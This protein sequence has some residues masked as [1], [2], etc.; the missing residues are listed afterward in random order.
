MPYDLFYHTVRQRY[1]EENIPRLID[2]MGRLI[3]RSA[4]SRALSSRHATIASRIVEGRPGR[5]SAEIREALEA[6]LLG[7]SRYRIPIIVHHSNTV[8]SR[9][10]KSI[11]NNQ[12][13]V[14]IFG[15][16]T[17]IDIYRKF[18]KAFEE[19]AFFWQQFGLTY[20]HAGQH[21]L[22]LETLSHAVSIHNHPY[23]RHA[24][25]VAKLVTC[26]E[27]GPQGLGEVNFIRFRSEG[28]I[29]LEEVHVEMQT[30]E[31]YG[32]SALVHHNLKISNKYDT[33]EDR[34]SIKRQ[35]HTMLAL[36]LRVHPNMLHAQAVYDRLHQELTS[37]I[38]AISKD[39]REDSFEPDI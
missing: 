29:E 6:L 14:F 12:F 25:A 15:E 10:F 28:T 37:D 36:Y 13:L 22:A 1:P 32:I 16:Q 5:G 31:D 3:Q 20:L 4:G 35:Y 38:P 2:S 8:H 30:R 34:S 11:I 9:V 17:A 18:E 33:E 23:I 39:L 19:D 7:F 26:F 21:E 27:K 24:L